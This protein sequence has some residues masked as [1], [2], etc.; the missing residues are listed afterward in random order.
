[1]NMYFPHGVP[2][3]SKSVRRFY[4]AIISLVERYPVQ[5]IT[6]DMISAEAE[7][8]RFTFYKYFSN[9]YELLYYVLVHDLDEAGIDCYDQ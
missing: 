7:T 4:H 6:V 9:K 1:M 3:F 5:K 2:K 8:S